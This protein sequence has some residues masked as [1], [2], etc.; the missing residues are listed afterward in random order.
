MAEIKAAVE[1]LPTL[2]RQEML[3]Y[4][5]P[6]FEEIMAGS[7][8]LATKEQVDALERRLTDLTDLVKT[9]F[10]SMETRFE[11]ME[12]RFESMETRFQSIDAKLDQVLA[13][14]GRTAS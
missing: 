11:S 1:Q 3:D 2:I 10:E 4:A 14:V 6:V 8:T 7:A 13:A 5:G 12:T 9:R